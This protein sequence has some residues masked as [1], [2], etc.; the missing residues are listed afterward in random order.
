MAVKKGLFVLLALVLGVTAAVFVY[1]QQRRQT[2]P[3]VE[4]RPVIREDIFALDV[5]INGRPAEEYRH[6][7]RNYVEALAGEEYELRVRNPLGARVAVALYPASDS[8]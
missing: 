3:S 8:S 4:S 7:G 2:P 5:L 1:A 6:R